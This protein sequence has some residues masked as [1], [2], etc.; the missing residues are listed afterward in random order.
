MHH[1][2]SRRLCH[3]LILTIW[4][5]ARVQQ[6]QT[7]MIHKAGAILDWFSD[8]TNS[9]KQGSSWLESWVALSVIRHEMEHAPKNFF[10]VRD[11]KHILTVSTVPER[12]CRR[13]II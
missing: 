7:L 13:R 6:E 9:D 12:P 10:E 5:V 1:V 4:Q 8:Y 3:F 2:L 11:N